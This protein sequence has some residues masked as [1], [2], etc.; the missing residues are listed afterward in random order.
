MTTKN[1]LVSPGRDL[2][3]FR[4]SIGDPSKDKEETDAVEDDVHSVMCERGWNELVRTDFMYQLE[5]ETA[6]QTEQDRAAAAAAAATTT[7][8]ITTT[9]TTILLLMM[10][11]MMMTSKTRM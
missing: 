6:R 3:S 9:T 5:L 4:R 8:I 11:I 2:I 7:T 10:M 1:R